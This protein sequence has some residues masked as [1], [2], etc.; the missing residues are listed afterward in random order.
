MDAPTRC[1]VSTTTIDRK[2]GYAARRR[3]LFLWFVEVQATYQRVGW[4]V[5]LHTSITRRAGYG[6]IRV[7]TYPRDVDRSVLCIALYAIRIVRLTTSSVTR[8]AP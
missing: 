6:S 2:I 3:E 7:T 8:K 1:R 4:F 5:T